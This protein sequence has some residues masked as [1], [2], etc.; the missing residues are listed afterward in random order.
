M[1]R[2]VLT[3]VVVLGAAIIVPSSSAAAPTAPAFLQGHVDTAVAASARAA[4][5]GA[6]TDVRSQ[7][8][9]V[10][11]VYQFPDMIG[12]RAGQ[13]VPLAVLGH[14]TTDRAGDYRL[15]IAQSPATARAAFNGGWV[16][17]EVDVTGPTG[18]TQTTFVSRRWSGT[19]WT[20]NN[21]AAAVARTTIPVNSTGRG[22]VGQVV[23]PTITPAGGAPGAHCNDFV[24]D[25]AVRE[26][27]TVLE[28][29]NSRNTTGNWTYGKQADS[30]IGIA[31]QGSSGWGQVSGSAQVS[32]THVRSVY[33]NPINGH[34]GR[35]AQTIFTFA[36]GHLRRGIRC[37]NPPEQVRPTG[38]EGDGE[39]WIGDSSGATCN[40]GNRVHFR[41]P[42]SLNGGAET[43]DQHAAVFSRGVT[44]GGDVTGGSSVS[45]TSTSGYSQ[46]V[47]LAWSW[48]KGGGVMCGTNTYP[49]KAD[50][51][52]LSP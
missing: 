26:W 32:N 14:A 23:P 37:G 36:K 31:V 16:N 19:A 4:T 29:H 18:A 5:S 47:D 1:I 44:F 11:T 21:A 34:F 50:I 39:R 38:W 17:A 8:G 13:V 9:A 35:Y 20:R 51:V 30:S 52:Y 7:A 48:S 42:Y 10:V 15:D 24:V 43:S 33:V 40:N 12:V 41:V 3:T 27:A 49:A 28:F 46:N 25:K 22:I 45:V 6:L 2:T